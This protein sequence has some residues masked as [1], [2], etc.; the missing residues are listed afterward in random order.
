[1]DET[2]ATILVNGLFDR[3]YTQ[4]IRYVVGVTRSLDLAED[5]VQDAFMQLYQLLRSG[6]D[7]EHPKA[8]TLCVLRRAVIRQMQ[9]RSRFEQLDEI[10]IAQSWLDEGTDASLNRRGQIRNE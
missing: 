6:K 1:M 10:E 3:W 8:W 7:I 2:D 5:L 9:N 4:L